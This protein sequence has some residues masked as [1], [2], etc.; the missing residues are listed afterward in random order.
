MTGAARRC[1]GGFTLVEL[2]TVVAIVAVLATIGTP[3]FREMLLNQR[4]AAAAQAFNSA[5]SLA[6]MEAIQRAQGVKVVA[7]AGNEWSG[8]WAVRTGPDESPQTLR[9]FDRLPQGVSV[10]ATLGSGFAQGLRYDSN[11]FSRQTGRS[12]FG[13]GCLT[14]KADTG[15][16]ASIVVSAS[17]RA[18]VCNPDV[19]GDC[20]SGACARSERGESGA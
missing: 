2:V 18:R 5:L 10:D 8:G 13:A 20:G 16:R 12:G 1:N 3:S 19:S 11:G 17:G 9:S 4:L 6:R 15:R 7:L 14:L